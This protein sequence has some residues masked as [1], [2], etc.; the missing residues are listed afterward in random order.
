[1]SMKIVYTQSAR[2]DLREIYEYIR[3]VL[4]EPLTAKRVTENIQREIRTL[5]LFP[6][7]NPLYREEPWRSQGLRFLV[8]GNYLVFYK[9]DNKDDTVSV[10]R[11]LYGGRD[12][13][14]QL[15]ETVLET[16]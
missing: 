14:K 9:A 3:Y 13:V 7:S 5:E 10:V 15:E 4:L 8:V 1:M 11:I 2:Q 16:P 12:I 6:E